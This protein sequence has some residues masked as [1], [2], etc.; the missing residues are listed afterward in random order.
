VLVL[1]ASAALAVEFLARSAGSTAGTRNAPAEIDSLLVPVRGTSGTSGSGVR[2]SSDP[3]A[4]RQAGS[5]MPTVAPRGGVSTVSSSGRRTRRL[6]AILTVDQ[7][8]IAVIDD[9]I[10]KVGDRLPDGARVDAIEADRVS[11]VEQNGQRRVLTLTRGR[12]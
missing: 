6:T 11:V 5:S 10:M 2:L 7:R 1:A 3:L 8:S 4:P 12:Q 9:Q